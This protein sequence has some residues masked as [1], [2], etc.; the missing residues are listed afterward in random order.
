[1]RRPVAIV[2]GAAALAAVVGAA[3]P[4]T[5]QAL[6]A[7]GAAAGTVLDGPSSPAPVASPAATV[8]AAPAATRAAA[9]PTATTVPAAQLV[10]ARQACTALGGQLVVLDPTSLECSEV[11]YVGADGT[12]Y[13]T[14]VP[15]SYGG[16]A[17]GTPNTYQQPAT[18]EECE[19][20]DYPFAPPP[21]SG[22][23]GTWNQ[24][25][26]LCQPAGATTAMPP[27]PAI[28]GARYSMLVNCSQQTC[29][30]GPGAGPNNSTCGAIVDNRQYCV[31]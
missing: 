4:F 30:S 11:P 7:V 14:S 12:T 19:D 6:G 17:T 25:L 9:T 20:G 23:P 1:M 31:W 3:A 24:N 26:N 2:L 5:D 27:M 15:V 10:Q 29:T 16:A 18:L 21:Q 28:N 13:Y 8:H 22:M